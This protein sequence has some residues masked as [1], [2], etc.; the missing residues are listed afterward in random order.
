MEVCGCSSVAIAV[1][2]ATASLG[3]RSGI[4]GASRGTDKA[5]HTRPI[6]GDCMAGR[7]NNGVGQ[8]VVMLVVAVMV[9]VF[10]VSCMDLSRAAL[11]E[12]ALA[13]GDSYTWL[14][15]VDEWR[16]SGR[17]RPVVPSHNAPYGLE[18]HLTLPFAALVRGLAQSFRL[19]QS[20][21]EA[22]RIA[23]M[24][25]GP[26]LHVA[27]AIA[28]AW[29]CRVLVGSGGSLLVVVGFLAMSLAPFRFG[30]RLFDHHSLHVFLTAL[31]TALLLRHATR[32]R[33]SGLLVAAAG[34]V[35]GVGIW[36][37]TEMFIPAGIGGLALSL[38]WAAWGGQWRVRGLWLYAVGMAL[39]L[40]A[41]IVVERPAVQWTS[42]GFD[43]LSGTHVLIGALLAGA[44]RG[45]FWLQGRWPDIKAIGRTG[46]GVLATGGVAAA[47]WATAPEFLLG[48][49]GAPDPVV[50]DHWQG[51]LGNHGVLVWLVSAPFYIGFH[52]C[53][54]AVVI[55]TVLAGLRSS[56]R[57][58]AW[59]VLATGA[60]VGAAV[61][62]VQFRLIQYYEVFACVA[63][64]A[65]AA[66][67][68]RFVWKR[69]PVIVR[70]AAAPAV[71][72]V[73]VLPVL[74]G[75]VVSR[76][77][78]TTIHAKWESA[79]QDRE[80]NWKELGHALA[81]LP[82]ERSGTIATYAAPGPELA[83]FSGRGVVATGCHC[84]AAGM[85][86]ART[87]LLKTP[88]SAR[89]VAERRNLEFVVQCSSAR[90]WQGHEWY[91]KR[92]GPEGVYARLAQGEP[93]V[94]LVQVPA[95]ELGLDDFDVWRTVF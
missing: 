55:A 75:L 78:P 52:L 71:L 95:S 19:S 46:V 5:F 47:T 59:M 3:T 48:Q 30:V 58:D 34:V 15:L 51:L 37:G 39:A 68:G 65:G 20:P 67:A 32:K 12:E 42:P 6:S 66:G 89:G 11:E 45:I 87:I 25:L 57:R 64:G 63:L 17:W 14:A 85:R 40:A 4:R 44:T 83:H 70:L 7:L 24:L 33:E 56:S 8:C 73:L 49:Y 41:A 79:Y 27:T 22:D 62:F 38:A 29:G 72:V 69:A 26:V 54:A 84:N 88:A 35:A 90:G 74:G 1:D 13:N 92:S 50:A 82:G 91:M 81:R 18:T 2:V 23:G 9:L 16:E 21:A 28:L 10:Q 77:V 43:R 86:D 93:P 94:W 76:F 80:C 60:V 53:L 36:A 61:A 31:L